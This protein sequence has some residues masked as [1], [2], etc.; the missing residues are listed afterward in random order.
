MIDA[1][2]DGKAQAHSPLYLADGTIELNK[3]TEYLFLVFRLDPATRIVH[4]NLETISGALD[5]K[6]YEPRFRKAKRI[7]QQI[8]YKPRKKQRVAVYPSIGRAGC[9]PRQSFIS[10]PN[11]ELIIELAND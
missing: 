2:H 3:I 6:R 9:G 4:R 5:G 1:S 8:A 11:L 7:V 10:R